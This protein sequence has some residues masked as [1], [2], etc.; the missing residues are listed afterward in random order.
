VFG[1]RNLDNTAAIGQFWQWW[2]QARHRVAGGIEDGSVA[3]LAGEISERVA[4]INEGLQ[5]ELTPGRTSHHGLVVTA[6]GDPALRAT[7]SRWLEAAPPADATFEYVG[8][9]QPDDRAFTARIRLD[10]RE[11]DL[12]AIR[13]AYATDEHGHN[14]D[15][16]VFH[17]DFPDLPESSRVQ[18][19]FLSLDWALGEEQVEL[20]VRGVDAPNQAPADLRTLA[21]FRAAVAEVAA[22]HAEPVYAMLQAETD[23]GRPLMALVQVP[24]KPARWPRFDTHVGIRLG[25]PAAGSGLPDGDS[26]TRLRAAED[27]VVEAVGG[28]GDVVAHETCDGVRTLHIYVDGGTPAADAAASAAVPY[29]GR[30]EVTYDPGLERVGHLRI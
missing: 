21:E 20:W 10:G 18:V 29:D 2:S 4:A 12:S 17:P 27:A 5:W 14:V 22:K 6:A 26:L 3:A 30:V 13:F 8:S 7:V 15:V 24:L 11:L 9:R 28:D 1:R 23:H 16:A 25:Y 19:A